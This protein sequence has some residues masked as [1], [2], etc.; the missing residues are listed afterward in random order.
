M[1][2]IQDRYYLWK[3]RKNNILIYRK[4]ALLKGA[5]FLMVILMSSIMEIW[6]KLCRKVKELNLE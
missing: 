4:A 6:C 5:A 3:G 2:T 1:I